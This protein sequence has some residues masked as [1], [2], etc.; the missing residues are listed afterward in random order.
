MR[1][2]KVVASLQSAAFDSPVTSPTA[3]CS[4][5]VSNCSTS[6]SGSVRCTKKLTLA[7]IKCLSAEDKRLYLIK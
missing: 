5:S 7:E 4:G 3:S 1:L 6:T 2:R